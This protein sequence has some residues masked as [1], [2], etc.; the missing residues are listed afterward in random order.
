MLERGQARVRDMHGSKSGG[1]ACFRSGKLVRRARRWRFATLLGCRIGLTEEV[2]F[3]M[4]VKCLFGERDSWNG[5][6]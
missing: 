2:C 6:R 1:S 5:R 3:E 4:R